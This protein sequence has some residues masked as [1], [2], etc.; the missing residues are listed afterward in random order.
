MAGEHQ[1]HRIG[2]DSLYPNPRGWADGPGT[3]VHGDAP[4]FGTLEID[5]RR[6][7]CQAHGLETA[8]MSLSAE[9]AA[10][11]PTAG[12]CAARTFV[13]SIGTEIFLIVAPVTPKEMN[14]IKAPKPRA[15]PLSQIVPRT[16][17]PAL[18]GAR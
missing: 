1:R 10:H 14:Q 9:P 7:L 11:S 12:K 15:D 8:R 2:I 13:N 16:F 4:H 17:V 5:A 18:R 6:H 3:E